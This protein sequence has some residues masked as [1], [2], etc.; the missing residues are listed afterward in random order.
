LNPDF[1]LMR[2]TSP[3]ISMILLLNSVLLW[4]PIWPARGTWGMTRLGTHGPMDATAL[5][6]FLAFR[7][8]IL[9]PHL[10]TGPW[11]PLPFVTPMISMP[12]LGPKTSFTDTVWPSR[13]LAYSSW[14][15]IDP[16]DTG[17]SKRSGAFCERLESLGWDAAM[18]LISATLSIFSFISFSLLSGWGSVAKVILLCRSL[19]WFCIQ[20]SVIACR[21]SWVFLYAR[22]A[23]TS[24][25]GVSITVAAAF[26]S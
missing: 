20:A 25:G 4:K 10:L 18:T 3:F 12:S 2:S 19:G 21:P 24:I 7:A 5:L 1:G 11:K 14:S 17:I 22:I 15:S 8:S 23:T 9:I 16:P 6:D 13:P 26:T